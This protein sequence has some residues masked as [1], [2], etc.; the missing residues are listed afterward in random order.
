MSRLDL[1]GYNTPNDEDARDVCDLIFGAGKDTD[2]ATIQ[3]FENYCGKRGCKG[4]YL[5]YT[6][7]PIHKVRSQLNE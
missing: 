3:M 5:G 1:T 2:R 7:N 4:C 6:E